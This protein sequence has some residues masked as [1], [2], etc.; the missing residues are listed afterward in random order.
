MLDSPKAPIQ[1]VDASADKRL[2]RQVYR[3][4]YIVSVIELQKEQASADHVHREIR[5]DLDDE[6]S[7]V[8]AAL[9]DGVVVGTLRITWGHEDLPLRLR[10]QFAL[11][12]F[13]RFRLDE[14]SFNSRLAIDAFFRD[15]AAISA[16]FDEAYTLVRERGSRVNFCHCTPGLVRL[17]EQLGYR[18]YEEAIVHPDSGFHIPMVM[19]TEDADHLRRVRSPLLRIA[20]RY[21]NE[22]EKENWFAR[23]FPEY[24]MG[25]VHAGLVDEEFSRALV[26]EMYET[27]IALFKGL[28]PAATEKFVAASRVVKVP[29]GE[30][31]VRHGDNGHEMYLIL[32]GAAEVQRQVDGCTCTIATLGKGQIVGE[33]AFVSRRARTASVVAID[34]VEVLV[35]TQ[36]FI[37]DLTRTMPATVIQV[38]LNLSVILADRLRDTNE[39]L[40]AARSQH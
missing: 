18:R 4:R 32:S 37:K 19:L 6:H 39:Q 36:Q 10:Q 23:E 5:D 26:N 24:A 22:A 29:K 13:L 11:Q 1:V 3:L 7:T 38:L 12:R 34:D 16:L 8:L 30:A 9:V 33:M 17:Y 31:I 21:R 40:L 14:S 28:T 25:G 35:L 27:E 20:Q 15:G 2:L